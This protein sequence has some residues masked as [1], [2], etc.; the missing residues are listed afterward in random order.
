[1]AERIIRPFELCAK[2]PLSQNSEKYALQ[3]KPV[4]QIGQLITIQLFCLLNPEGNHA[5]LGGFRIDR[6]SPGQ[7]ADEKT[8]GSY[9]SRSNGT[10][11][12]FC[13][14]PNFVRDSQHPS[15]S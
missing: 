12:D 13:P 3:E 8:F 11:P 6:Y 9:T 5:E 15:S 1:M 10:P 7:G 14:N 2:C 4:G